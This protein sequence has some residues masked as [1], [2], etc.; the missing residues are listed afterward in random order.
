MSNSAPDS[1]SVF[2]ARVRAFLDGRV[3]AHEG[4]RDLVHAE[5]ARQ[6]KHEHD[7]R[8]FRKLRMAAGEHQPQLVVGDSDRIENFFDRIGDRPLG[9]QQASQVRCERS[10]RALAPQN[11]ESAILC[12]LHQPRR[13]I[14]R[15]A[16]E[17][18]N[19]QRAAEGVLHDV[20]CQRE[21]VK[22]EHARE[23][24]DH[25]SRF[26]AEQVVAKLTPLHV[27]CPSS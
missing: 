19:L 10:C 1:A 24:C 4:A 5:T 23:R 2:F 12:R 8:G 26:V 17:F 13:R 11:V 14:L 18:P 25:P 3:G 9:L 22:T 21:V 16:A 6:L 20:F 7:L 15:N 27:T